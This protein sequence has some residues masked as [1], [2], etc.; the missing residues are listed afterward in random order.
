MKSAVFAVSLA[1]AVAAQGLPQ[2]PTDCLNS[3]NTQ[4]A[5][6]LGCQNNDFKCLCTKQDW[7]FGIRDCVA[8]ACNN[9]QLVVD[10]LNNAKNTCAQNGVQIDVNGIN[11]SAGG[12]T[13]CLATSRRQTM[14]LTNAL[15]PQNSG[16][17]NAPPPTASAETTVATVFSTFSS[18][19]SLASTPLVTTTIGA[20]TTTTVTAGSTTSTSRGFAA[21]VTAAPAAGMLAAAGLAALMM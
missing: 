9:G 15:G 7:V 18:G 3:M 12:P 19:G 20:E 17:V 8:Q 4:K 5:E 14:T 21:Q 13:V 2:C 6:S 1:A 11:T 16:V 10:A